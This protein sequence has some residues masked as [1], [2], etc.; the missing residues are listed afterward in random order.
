MPRPPARHVAR[1]PPW[2]MSRPQPAFRA[3]GDAGAIAGRVLDIGCGTGEHALL[4]AELGVDATGVDVSSTALAVATRAAHQRGLTARLLEH[5]ACRL[6]ELGE[7]FDTVLDCGLFHALTRARRTSLIDSLRAVIPP[8][9]HYF[10]LGGWGP[11][12]LDRLTIRNAFT[13]GWHIDAIEPADVE[14][15][16]APGSLPALLA[17]LTRT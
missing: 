14:V 6:G 1:T 11:H 8:G 12:R 13:N 9:G 4:A 10:I 15:N 17:K 5:D 16:I 7:R 2:E 3:L